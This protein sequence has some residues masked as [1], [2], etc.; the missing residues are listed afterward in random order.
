MGYFDALLSGVLK[1]DQDGRRLFYPYGVLSKGYVLASSDAEAKIKKFCVLWMMLS[2]I[3]TVVFFLVVQKWFLSFLVT[4]VLIGWYELRIRQLLSGT[5][6]VSDRL[7]YT[8]SLSGTAAKLDLRFLWFLE[9]VSVIFLLSGL[10]SFL[11]PSR[12]RF[13][14]LVSVLFFGYGSFVFWHMIRLKKKV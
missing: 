11:L 9:V 14:D 7:S 6:L 1:T 13:L 4:F 8:Q 5:R 10:A 12:R 2:V 3:L